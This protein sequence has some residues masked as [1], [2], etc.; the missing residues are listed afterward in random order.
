MIV[1]QHII[2]GLSLSFIGSLPIGLINMAVAETAIRKGLKAA[3]WMALGA[4]LVEFV[5][6]M[7]AIK[8][9]HLISGN[10]RFGMAFNG[11]AALVFLLLA[12]YY[13]FLLRPKAK[14]ADAAGGV[15]IPN[16]Y[17]GM[18]VSSLNVLVFP[19][20]IFYGAYLSANGW[21]LLSNGFLALFC[22]G[23]MLGALGALALYARLG[24][25]VVSRTEQVTHYANRVVGLIFLGFGVYQVFCFCELYFG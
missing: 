16:F 13:L 4:A 22:L 19:Y 17:K 5:Q 18:A 6:S 20:W 11:V 9:T 3:L 23:T 15:N 21:L 2:L 14:Q 8:F 10:V 7:V 24:V 12:L 1:L 25:F